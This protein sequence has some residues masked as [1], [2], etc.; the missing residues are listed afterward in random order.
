MATLPDIK[1]A[2]VNALNRANGSQ[3]I[4][5]EDIVLVSAVA[6]DAQSPTITVKLK[7][8]AS[9]PKLGTY[10]VVLSRIP[11]SDFFSST[12]AGIGSDF[13]VPP[14]ETVTGALKAIG[15]NNGLDL[16]VE[17]FEEGTVTW[18]AGKANVTVSAKATSLYFYGSAQLSLTAAEVDISTAFTRNSINVTT[19]SLTR[20][21]AIKLIEGVNTRLYP[22]DVFAFSKAMTLEE[23][24][25]T[26]NTFNSV[27]QVTGQPGSG[28]KGVYNIFFNRIDLSTFKDG[29]S[30][31]DDFK[32]SVLDALQYENMG[33]RTS[34]D[35]SEMQDGVID[36]TTSPV[37][38]TLAGK[39]DSYRVFKSSTVRLLRFSEDTQ[40][41]TIDFT[42]NNT[43]MVAATLSNLC[44]AKVPKAGR[45]N[46]TVNVANDIYLVGSTLTDYG[47]SIQAMAQ[48]GEVDLTL[49][50]RGFITGRGQKGTGL[51][52]PTPAGPGLFVDPKFRGR[53][54]INN[55]GKIT[56]GGGGGAQGSS[57]YYVGGGGGQPLGPISNTGTSSPY[58]DGPAATL[59]APGA[60]RQVWRSD[61]LY[62]WG[63]AGGSLGQP[64]RQ[65][66][67][68]NGSPPYYAYNTL[69]Q[70]ADPGVAVV[71]TGNLIEWQ[72]LGTV[73]PVL[74]DPVKILEE[75]AAK[76]GA[77]EVSDG[78]DLSQTLEKDRVLV[79]LSGDNSF[80]TTDASGAM[81][82]KMSCVGPVWMGPVA[83][84]KVSVMLGV[85][86]QAC[87]TADTPYWLYYHKYPVY[88]E[89]EAQAKG[90]DIGSNNRNLQSTSPL[91]NTTPQTRVVRA[92]Y[93]DPYVGKLMDANPYLGKAV[94]FTEALVDLST[95]S[96]ELPAFS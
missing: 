46:L 64:G 51:F 77:R 79:R 12:V 67:S 47:L 63:G 2:A 72:T 5:P 11:L 75:W 83:R 60:A 21:A 55:L 66:K 3:V 65:A 36:Y 94:P 73:L 22:T 54:R 1:S 90:V 29:F 13:V 78:M 85:V 59:T 16:A 86:V 50:N 62:Y 52:E 4:S 34:V 71:D 24:G 42:A 76:Q 15:R 40:S 80:Y 18:S 96:G 48:Y 10:E 30:V 44:K 23:A 53:V 33:L 27:I 89:F 6:T 70:P 26:P 95:A 39:P 25:I 57:L 7:G 45:L 88:L 82:N 20:E 28:Y 38:L 68:Q 35:L 43:N 58:Y 61:T 31:P 17:Q 56:G 84:H 19:T 41:L 74:Y 9:K 91:G 93:F 92:V 49:N 32:G 8:I 37:L 14:A 69:R 87:Q 81:V